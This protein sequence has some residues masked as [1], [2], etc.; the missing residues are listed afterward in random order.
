[1]DEWIDRWMTEGWAPT[2]V[3]PPA[4]AAM[5]AEL[6]D[7]I[8]WFQSSNLL[9]LGLVCIC[10]VVVIAIA[11][12][13]GPS[14]M[15]TFPIPGWGSCGVIAVGIKLSYWLRPPI[16]SRPRRLDFK[17]NLDQKPTQL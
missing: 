17:P 4:Q 10:M 14:S 7:T 8:S 13:D 3:S 9:V 6:S 5:N 11:T 15:G 12:G 1:M 2:Q 16:A